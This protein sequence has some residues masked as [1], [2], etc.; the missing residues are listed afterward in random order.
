MTAEVT[1][2]ARLGRRTKDLVKRLRPGDVAIIDHADLDRVSAEELA[3]VGRARGR[4]RRPI[5]VRAFPEPGA[6]R[7]RPGRRAPGRRARRGRCS[8]RSRDGE[9]SASAAAA[10]G[11]T[12][13]CLAEGVELDEAHARH[14]PR[15]AA[16]PGDGRARGV[17]R[18]HAAPPA[19]RGPAARARGSSSR[20]SRRGSA[21]VTRSS[22]R[23]AP[24][25]SATSASCGRTSATSGRCSSPSTGEPMRCSRSGSSRT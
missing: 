18:Q 1:G 25:T 22:S 15:R 11:A 9:R 16:E 2:T 4:Q 23:A 8:T 3:D 5:D 21:T 24:A 10:S 17:R 12:E 13:R 6:A 19:R 7:A 20:R 14:R